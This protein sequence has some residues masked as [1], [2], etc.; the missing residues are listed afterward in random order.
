ME[1]VGFE[2]VEYC[3]QPSVVKMVVVG[4]GLAMSKIWALRG[5]SSLGFYPPVDFGPLH[6]LLQ[7]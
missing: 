4:I 3:R 6:M 7:I 2:K 1:Q 5:S